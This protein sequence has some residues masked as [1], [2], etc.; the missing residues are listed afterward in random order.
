MGAQQALAA[1]LSATLRERGLS[2]SFDRV[3]VETIV[4]RDGPDALTDIY[5]AQA[6][7]GV[8]Y[9]RAR[10]NDDGRKK[11]LAFVSAEIPR[12]R[13]CHMFKRWIGLAALA[14]FLALPATLS[15]QN[16]PASVCNDGT[17][18]TVTGKGACSGHGGVNHAA[19]KQL[20][21]NSAPPAPPSTPNANTAGTGVTCNDGTIPNATGKGACAHHGGFKTTG[22]SPNATPPAPNANTAG[23][24]VTC[25]DGTIPNATGKGACAHHGGF[26]T[27]GTSPNATPP[28]PN[29]NTAG[30]GAAC[31]DGTIS[32]TTGKGACAHHGGLKTTSTS[33]NA[34]A[35]PPSAPPGPPPNF[36]GLTVPCADGTTANFGANACAGHGGEKP[37]GTIGHSPRR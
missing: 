22:T 36:L 24:G 5:R 29:A 31:N 32:N 9:R 12:F 14:A 19:T 8:A 1:R 21:A 16:G 37:G 11:L 13:R 15:A 17:T 34:P 18:S 2:V 4:R 26:K 25:N 3:D 7:V 30:T 6:R 10:W 23:T 35:A 27:T 20:H 33:P 28:A